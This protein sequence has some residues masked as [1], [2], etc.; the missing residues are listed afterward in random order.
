[1]F[2]QLLALFLRSIALFQGDAGLIPRFCEGLFSRIAEATR[3]DE[4]SFRTE[5]RWGRWGRVRSQGS[6]EVCLRNTQVVVMVVVILCCA[7]AA[8]WRSTT[9]ECA[10]CSGGNPPRL[11]TS[12]CGSTRR[13][14]HM[15]KVRLSL[16]RALKNNSAMNS[17]FTFWWWFSKQSERSE[18][19]LLSESWF[20]TGY[21]VI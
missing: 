1:M 4:A 10:T 18:P 20:C 13:T 11:T 16:Q 15:W 14:G 8:T 5:V 7:P 3:W 6:G 21:G 17:G 9:R 19:E 12:G 2:P